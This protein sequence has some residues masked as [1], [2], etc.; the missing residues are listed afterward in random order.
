MNQWSFREVAWYFDNILKETPSIWH[1]I[2]QL[3][4]FDGIVLRVA[5]YSGESFF[6]E[7][8]GPNRSYCLHLMRD[9]LDKGWCVFTDNYYNSLTLTKI[10][11]E[12]SI[13]ICGTLWPD[14]KGNPQTVIQSKLKRGEPEWSGREGMIVCKWKDK[15][16]VLTISNLH[17]FQMVCVQN[18]YA[19]RRQKPLTVRGYNKGMSGIDRSDQ[20]LSYHSSL[21]K[22]IRWYKKIAL[23]MIEMFIFNAHY[24]FSMPERRQS[25]KMR[26]L[27]FRECIVRH[28][29]GEVASNS[30]TKI[31]SSKESHFPRSISP[32]VKKKFPTKPCRV[33]KQNRI[34]RESR[35]C[36]D[37]CEEQ[38]ALCVDPCFRLFH[39]L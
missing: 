36:C 23:N 3:C 1:K 17:R 32:R 22:T 39:T 27:D 20:M 30:R 5:I 33:C 15:R 10:M 12:R 16:D 37:S 11:S 21:R 24:M 35:Y 25:N 26:L 28:L 18:K 8:D 31:L 9:Y 29:V 14:R 6:D 38:P 7:H 19:V 34:K 4:E 2:F 13:Y